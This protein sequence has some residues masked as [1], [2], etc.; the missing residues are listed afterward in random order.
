[1]S[2]ADKLLEKLRNGT[3]SAREVRTLLGQLGW[4]LARQK[5]SHEQWLKNGK[6]LTLATHSKEVKP[7]QLKQIA[8]ALEE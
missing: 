3:I 1:M 5:G 2:K 8:K 6:V 4:S 7:Y